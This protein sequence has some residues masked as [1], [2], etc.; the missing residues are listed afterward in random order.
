MSG[1]G[2]RERWLLE[3]RCKHCEKRHCGFKFR[4]RKA[5]DGW[6][7]YGYRSKHW[8]ERTWL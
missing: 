1:Y 7:C 3:N 8:D 6:R 5:H 2:T 4:V